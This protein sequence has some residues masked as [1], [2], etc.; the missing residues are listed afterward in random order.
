M[1]LFSKPYCSFFWFAL[2]CLE[3]N[4]AVIKTKMVNA[5]VMCNSCKSG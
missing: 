4:I 5:I 2:C 3:S 1:L